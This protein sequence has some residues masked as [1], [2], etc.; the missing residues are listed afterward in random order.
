MQKGKNMAYYKKSYKK[1]YRNSRKRRSYSKRRKFNKGGTII[2]VFLHKPFSKRRKYYKKKNN[3]PT[4][5]FG[6]T[7]PPEQI[8]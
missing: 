1:N 2:N 7:P 5:L 4:G 8:T 6:L 3:K